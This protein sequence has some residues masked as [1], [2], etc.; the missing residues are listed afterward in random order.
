MINENDFNNEGNEVVKDLNLEAKIEKELLLHGCKRRD[1]TENQLDTLRVEL[2]T[3]QDGSCSVMNGFWSNYHEPLDNKGNPDIEPEPKF[4]I[5][6]RAWVTENGTGN[7]IPG[8]GVIRKID[9]EWIDLGEE[10]QGYWE[11]TYF[12]KNLRTPY[13]EDHVFAT[14]LEALAAIA[15]DFKRKT[16]SQA[17]EICR[18]MREVGMNITTKELLENISSMV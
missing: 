14:E 3:L 2:D 6:D 9:K 18:K 5:G 16:I 7:G 4:N 13:T 10:L 11:I 1:F 12:L 8:V 15:A 17:A